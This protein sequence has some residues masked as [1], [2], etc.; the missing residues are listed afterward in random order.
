MRAAELNIYFGI[1]SSLLPAHVLKNIPNVF[2]L[3]I[4]IRLY[5]TYTYVK[6][7]GSQKLLFK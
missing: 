3:N 6:I 2:N 4:R 1:F 7:R 5:C